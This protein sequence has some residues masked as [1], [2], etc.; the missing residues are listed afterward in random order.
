ME[1]YCNKAVHSEVG[2]S[3]RNNVA[4]RARVGR[5]EAG[6]AADGRPLD[7]ELELRWDG[8]ERQALDEE[9]ELSW[10]SCE[11]QTLWQGRQEHETRLC[12]GRISQRKLPI[13]APQL[14][15]Q[16][17]ELVSPVL[18]PRSFPVVPPQLGSV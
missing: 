9:T 17:L 10:D 6:M 3:T 8:C 14:V 13:T 5:R 2:R 15:L 1:R 16:L 11:R 12:I 18:H 7:E 4:S